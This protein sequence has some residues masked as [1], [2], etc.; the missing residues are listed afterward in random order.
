MLLRG[1]EYDWSIKQALSVPILIAGTEKQLVILN[2][3]LCMVFIFST[4]FDLIALGAIPLGLFMHGLCMHVSK[5]DARMLAV[6]QRSTR[7]KGYYHA[8]PKQYKEKL[9]D[10]VFGGGRKFYSLP[11]EL[12]R[13]K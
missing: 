3:T 11:Q 7:Y 10:K 9:I 12:R 6:F 5:R 4:H 2:A 1:K 13:Q 8:V